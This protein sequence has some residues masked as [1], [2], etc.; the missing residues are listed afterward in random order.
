MLSTYGV[1]DK[2]NFTQTSRTGRIKLRPNNIFIDGMTIS[3][4]Y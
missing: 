2:S 1:I 4:I 3:K